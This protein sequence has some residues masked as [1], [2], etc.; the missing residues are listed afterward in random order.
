[1][2]N[3]PFIMKDFVSNSS[4]TFVRNPNYWGKDPIGP[5]KGK[6]LPYLDRIDLFIIADTSTNQAAFR[7]G[8]LD[9]MRM[10]ATTTSL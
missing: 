8:K 10:W 3:G 1:M 6:Q 7:T 5:G 2:G 4:A 9:V